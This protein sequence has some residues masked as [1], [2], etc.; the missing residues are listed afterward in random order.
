MKLVI[1]IVVVF[2]EFLVPFVIY[3]SRVT[4]NNK[5]FRLHLAYCYLS[6]IHKNL[7]GV[8]STITN[9][10]KKARNKERKERK[11]QER[12]NKGRKQERKKQRK[13]DLMTEQS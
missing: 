5:L 8:I 2:S 7:Y 11:K 1:V 10:R 4:F 9:A 12:K 6:H 3:H 13:K